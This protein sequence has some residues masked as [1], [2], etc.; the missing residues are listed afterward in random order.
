MEKNIEINKMGSAPVGKLL[1]NMSLPAMVSML[2]MALYNVID[3]MFV[4]RIC[5]E[6]LTAVSIVFPAQMMVLALALGSS[7]G[8]GSLIARKL[9]AKNH[10]EANMAAA[11]SFALGIVN[12]MIVVVFC[13]FFSKIFVGFFADEGYLMD[14]ALSYLRITCYLS[15]FCFLEISVEKIMQSTG[16]TFLPMI[17]SL[18][19]AITN[20]ALDPILIFGLIGAPKLGVEGAAIATVTGQAVG[21]LV[22]I[23]LFFKCRHE[24]KISLKRFRF[25]PATLRE[26]YEVGVPVMMMQAITSVLVLGLNSI[27]IVFSKTAVAFLGIYFRVQS[28]IF[29]PVFGLSQGTMPILGYNFGAKNKER[30]L[31]TYKLAVIVASIIMG[32][33][34]LAFMIFPR[35]I[36]SMF[37]ANENMMAMGIPGLRIISLCFVPAAF[38]ITTS[39]L[40]QA[41]GK[42]KYSLYVSLLRQLILILPMAWIYSKIIGVTGVWWAFPSAE[43]FALI[44]SVV[45]FKKIYND[46]IKNLNQ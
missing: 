46:K 28:F 18:A 13:F 43:I 44:G 38:G 8:A 36:L 21:M 27:L 40:F 34:T 31:K 3:S 4:S 17:S 10:D 2:I 9:G 45:F 7:I 19:G 32:L 33:G 5:E 15:I 12:W 22:A 24:V 1:F 20:I 6:A 26:I 39:T 23:L 14:S 41:I 35:E 37:D 30:F 42:G 25:R 29:M 11:H 16:N